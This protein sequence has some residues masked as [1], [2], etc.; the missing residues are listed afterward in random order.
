M[1]VMF[2]YFMCFFCLFFLQ[3]TV[4]VSCTAMLHLIGQI[5]WHVDHKH[6]VHENIKYYILHWFLQHVYCAVVVWTTVEGRTTFFL[7]TSS[8]LCFGISLCVLENN[9]LHSKD[10]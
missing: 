3:I 7:L 6:T 4:F 9:F 5:C 10:G 1:K 2:L 8:L